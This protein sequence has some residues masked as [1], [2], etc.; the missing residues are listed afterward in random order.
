MKM[1]HT[2]PEARYGGVKKSVDRER[3]NTNVSKSQTKK[4]I[5]KGRG[6]SVKT[7][8]PSKKSIFPKTNK[9]PS[10]EDSYSEIDEDLE[11]DREYIQGLDKNIR[12]S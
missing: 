9:A 4:S 8:S 11:Q 6:M 7:S 5:E 3:S 10:V 2:G 12:E 1:G